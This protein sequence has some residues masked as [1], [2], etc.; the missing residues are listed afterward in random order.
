M[1]QGYQESRLDQNAKSPVG[2]IGIMQVMPATG[3]EHEGRRHHAARAQHPRRRQVHA[4]H[5][6]RV[7][8]Q[9]AD[10]PA[11]Q[12]ALHLRRLQRRARAASVSCAEAAERGL[13]PNVWFNN[14]ELVAAEKIGRETVTY[15]SNI[16]KYY[17]AYQMIEEERA[18]REKAKAAIKEGGTQ[19]VARCRF[20]RA[21][22]L[23]DGTGAPPVRDAVVSIDNG[24]IEA[25]TTADRA[26]A[27]RPARGDRRLGPHRAARPHRLPRPSRL[28]R[29]RAGE[30]LGPRRA[31]EHAASAHGRRGAQ[32]LESGYT[33]IRDA[34]G[35]D[36]GFRS[37]SR[38]G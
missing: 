27:C 12:G 11:Q 38:K 25:V 23:I 5:D 32:I 22:T 8:R 31:A 20:V 2:A 9:G 33:A 26:R 16:Y 37:R 3:E 29:L 19:A 15:V 24:R 4:L 7:L 34:G 1:A 30:A 28:P 6:E 35:L 17:L 14:V 18:E 21:G 13:D 36:A 10:G